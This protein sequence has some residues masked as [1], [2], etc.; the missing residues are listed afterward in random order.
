MISEVILAEVKKKADVLWISPSSSIL[1]RAVKKHTYSIHC[2]CEW[3]KATT[4]Y[5]DIKKGLSQSLRYEYMYGIDDENL[6]M[7]IEHGT[8]YLEE[9]TITRKQM[10]EF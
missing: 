4:R 10:K 6:S 7:Y 3:C 5:I 1:K 2:G 8:E 9:L